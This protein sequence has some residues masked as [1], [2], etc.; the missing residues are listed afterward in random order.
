M[1]ACFEKK[2][3]LINL[4]PFFVIYTVCTL[5]LITCDYFFHIYL[6][7]Q[8][9][10]QPQKGRK[11]K[12]EV[13]GQSS[14]SSC[15][16]SSLPAVAAYQRHELTLLRMEDLLNH[17]SGSEAAPLQNLG[18]SGRVQTAAELCHRMVDFCQRLTTAKRKILE[19]PDLYPEVR[20]STSRQ[21]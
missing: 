19:D 5:L 10:Q 14:I 7:E 18:V 2:K 21:A 9:Q 15:T 13:N 4:F 12:P 16:S 11:H 6:G 20:Y 8:Q 3:T 1:Y 17:G